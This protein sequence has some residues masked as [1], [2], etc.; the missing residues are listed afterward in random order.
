M[1]TGCRRVGCSCDE[2][3]RPTNMLPQKHE[4]DLTG[5]Y[6][7]VHIPQGPPDTRNLT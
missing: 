1:D 3:V 5:A 7:Q 2:P 4:E 6:S